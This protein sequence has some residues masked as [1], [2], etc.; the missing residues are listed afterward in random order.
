[1]TDRYVK[2]GR[3]P[4]L[5]SA[6]TVNH[7]GVKVGDTWYEIEAEGQKKVNKIVLK[8]IVE[9]LVEIQLNTQEE[10]LLEKQ[11]NQIMK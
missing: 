7:W 10:R 3:D 4:F 11:P 8:N 1:M 5:R 6:L 9:N 2:L